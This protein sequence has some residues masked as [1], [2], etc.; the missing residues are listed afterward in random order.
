MPRRP[1]TLA[2]VDR[3]GIPSITPVGRGEYVRCVI[4]SY[5]GWGKTSLIATGPE[6]GFKTLIIRSSA[7]LIPARALDSGADQFIADTW[8]DM[9]EILQHMRMTDH[10]YDWVWWDNISIAQDKLLD[11][12]WAAVLAVRP[13]RGA[14]T[15]QGGL[16]KGE[17]GRNMERIQQWVRHMVGANSFHFGIMAHPME[18]QHPTNDEGG[19]IL[20]PYVQGKQMTEKICGYANLVAFLELMEADGTQ[21]RRLHTRESPRWYAKDQYDAFPKGYID[22]P[23]VGKLMSSIEASKSGRSAAPTTSRRGRAKKGA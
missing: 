22:N 23:T 13:D 2:V 11:D 7:D 12:V 18:G 15:P 4:H 6:A 8:E 19:F 9:S 20:R 1:Q 17:Y 5:P 3:G 21:W 10:G 16:D 14:L